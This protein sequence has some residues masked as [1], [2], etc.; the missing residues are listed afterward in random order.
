MGTNKLS[1]KRGS[2]AAKLRLT[3]RQFAL[4]IA[5]LVTALIFCPFLGQELFSDVMTFQKIDDA[6]QLTYPAFMRA[7][8]VFVHGGVDVFS[9]NGAPEMAIR[10][11]LPMAYPLF[12]DNPKFCVTAKSGANREKFIMGGRRVKRLP[13]C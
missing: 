5:L 1:L 13:P 7:W 9:D 12:R 2:E 4:I 8:D 3:D 11:N 6:M 10:A